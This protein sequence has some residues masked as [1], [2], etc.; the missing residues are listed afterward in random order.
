MEMVKINYRIWPFF[1]NNLKKQKKKK[2]TENLFNFKLMNKKTN[3]ISVKFSLHNRNFSA[4]I[5]FSI[6]F[7]FL[8]FFFLNFQNNY[9]TIL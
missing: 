3:T 4:R 2:K 5:H 1:I 8:N 6:F 9:S 7:V